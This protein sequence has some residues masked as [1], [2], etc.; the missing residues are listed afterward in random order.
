MINRH[1][2]HVFWTEDWEETLEPEKKKLKQKQRG[3]TSSTW[4]GLGFKPVT[5]LCGYDANH[6]PAVLLIYDLICRNVVITNS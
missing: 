5:L 3:H 2:V 4:N 1:N 6:S